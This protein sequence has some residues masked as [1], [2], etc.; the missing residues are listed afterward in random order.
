LVT[1]YK[2][3]VE[4]LVSLLLSFAEYGPSLLD[5]DALSLFLFPFEWLLWRRWR[6]SDAL[7]SLRS[8]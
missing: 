5:L 7:S 4:T 6:S 3:T 1:G 8:S 2:D